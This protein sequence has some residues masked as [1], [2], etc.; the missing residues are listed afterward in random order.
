MTKPTT[1]RKTT[2]PKVAIAKVTGKAPP[3]PE[4]KTAPKKAAPKA[5]PQVLSMRTFV[6]KCASSTIL[7]PT[8]GTLIL[9]GI[10]N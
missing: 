8:S 5:K 10:R 2:A 4:V 1:T 6:C 7:H 3:E 9:R